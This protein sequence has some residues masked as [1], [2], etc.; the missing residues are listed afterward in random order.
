ML[1]H[2]SLHYAVY[3]NFNCHLLQWCAFKYMFK[4]LGY[5]LCVV[6]CYVCLV[7]LGKNAWKKE[8]N[9]MTN[10]DAIHTMRNDRENDCFFCSFWTGAKCVQ[11]VFSISQQ[12]ISSS[13][14]DPQLLRS[15]FVQNCSMNC[16]SFSLIRKY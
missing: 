14:L 13:T 1:F 3:L 16:S 8:T 9:N 11:N 12:A 2:I 4:E 6:L 5:L 7:M 15:N 10:I